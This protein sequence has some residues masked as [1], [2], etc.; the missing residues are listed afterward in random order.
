MDSGARRRPVADLHGG[1]RRLH[2]AVQGSAQGAGAAAQGLGRR[3]A[4]GRA[5]ARRPLF[6]GRGAGTPA[7]A[8]AAPVR[9]LAGAGWAPPGQRLGRRG[10]AGQVRVEPTGSAQVD[11]KCFFSKYF[12][13]AKINPELTR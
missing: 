12:S 11:R 3:A 5:R 1:R 10:R 13:C 4:G 2:A 8:A 6:M 9:P 7:Q